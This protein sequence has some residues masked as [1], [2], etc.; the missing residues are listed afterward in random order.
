MIL[1]FGTKHQEIEMYNIYINQ[2][3]GMTLSFF[4]AR[5]TFEWGKLFKCHLKG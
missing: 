3:H 4:T 5:S 1:K 2:D